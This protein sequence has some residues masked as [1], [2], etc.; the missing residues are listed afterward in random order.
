[1]AYIGGGFGA[2]IH[3]INEA[4]VFGIPVVFG[5]KHGKFQEASDLIGNGGG[6]SISNAQEFE[7][8]AN[9]MLTQ[10]KALKQAGDTAAS[11]IQSHL[12]AT[13]RIFADLF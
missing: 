11:Y 12:G 5:P 1:M 8:V 7:A 2:G 4:A 10:P 6:F 9:R 13:D 3:N